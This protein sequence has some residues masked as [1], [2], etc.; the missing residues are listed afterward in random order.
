MSIDYADTFDQIWAALDA[1]ATVTSL[2]SGGTK[3]RWT[4]GLLRRLEIE[5]V[6][7]PVLSLGPSGNFSLPFDHHLGEPTLPLLCEI[8]T[9]GQD[10]R[11]GLALM[12]AVVRCLIAGVAADRFGQDDLDRVEF[13]GANMNLHP[14][15]D[16]ANPLWVASFTVTCFYRVATDV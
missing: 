15:R 6:M 3:Y 9:R 16:A 12:A 5:P 1:D 14:G 7:C 8:A 2:M 11:D 4:G 13:S 10:C